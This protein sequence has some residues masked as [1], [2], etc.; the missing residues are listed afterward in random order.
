MYPEVTHVAFPCEE[1]LILLLPQL[2]YDSEPKHVG[3]LLCKKANVENEQELFFSWW[4]TSIKHGVWRVM[5]SRIAQM[6]PVSRD[7]L[8]GRQCPAEKLPFPLGKKECI[9]DP[10]KGAFCEGLSTPPFP[11]VVLA[12][13][14]CIYIL[15]LTRFFI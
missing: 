9:K 15:P 3:S 2:L 14:K 13:P 12:F 5:I 6:W 8:I 1:F 10:V 7:C 4:S 11:C